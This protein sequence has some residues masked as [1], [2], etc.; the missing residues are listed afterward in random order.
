M[1]K[2]ALSIGLLTLVMVLTSF[3]T[4]ETISSTIL[5]NTTNSPID[6]NGGQDTGRNR[7]KDYTGDAST[8]SLTNQ[9]VAIDGNG[10][11][12]T[13]FNRKKD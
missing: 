8:I 5:D 6:G 4:P 11:Q 3:T 12:D 10:G 13:G 7:K 9:I 2:A 1:K